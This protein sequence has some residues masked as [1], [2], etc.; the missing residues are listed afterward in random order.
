MLHY[1]YGPQEY[2]GFGG[3]LSVLLCFLVGYLISTLTRL[4]LEI[5]PL[6]NG[7]YKAVPVINDP[8]KE[9][10]KGLIYTRNI[11]EYFEYRL[12]WP[13]NYAYD[14]VYGFHD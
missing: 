10:L 4:S 1:G 3:M 6:E 7:A 9:D 13:R 8:S 12:N 14:A 5:S 11:S 2:L